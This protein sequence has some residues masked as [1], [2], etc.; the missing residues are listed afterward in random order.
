MCRGNSQSIPGG[1]EKMKKIWI[2]GSEANVSQRLG[3]GQVAFELIRNFAQINH[4][5]DITVLLPGIPLDDLPKESKSFHYKK[6]KITRLKTLIGIPLSLFSAKDKPDVYFSPSHYLPKFTPK[7]IRKVVTIF[8]LSYLHFSQMFKKGDL[9]KLTNW[10]KSS[11]KNADHVITISNSTK[12]DLLKNYEIGKNQ[13]T[14]AYP[15]YNDQLY[16]PISDNLRINAI[17]EKYRIGENYI[18]Y[19]GTI[20]PRKNL[21]R[22][23]EAFVSIDNLKLVIVGKTSGEGK[24]GW[25]YEDI[26]KLP[27]KLNISDKVIFTGFIDKEELKYLLNGAKAFILPSLYEGFGI[28]VIEAMACGIPVIVSDVSSLPE[29]VGSAG[30]LINPNSTDQIEMAIRNI[31]T[32]KK[33]HERLA[34]KGIERAKRYSWKKMAKQ[35]LKVL[36]N[37]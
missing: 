1:I 16:K 29:I 3:S 28:P 2:D 19:I 9:Y 7:E 36:E 18:I 17:K 22:L 30:L 25:M 31:I 11:L 27:E 26:L 20:Q 34:K 4:I 24:E 13:I 32:D 5:N 12:K 35:V 15:G 14:V 8:D 10:T 33:L 21:S 37:V 23:I 6:L